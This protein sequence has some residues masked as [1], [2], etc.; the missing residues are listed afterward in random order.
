M[1]TEASIIVAL[2][3]YLSF[4]AYGT[5][6]LNKE[7]LRA[8]V[9]IQMTTAMAGNANAIDQ[10]D[11]RLNPAIDALAAVIFKFGEQCK[12]FVGGEAIACG[13]C[14]DRHATCTCDPCHGVFK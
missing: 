4:A 11:A 14:N 9:K 6:V 7:G 2:P 10:I 1:T 12:L 13:V 5:K 3:S 8:W